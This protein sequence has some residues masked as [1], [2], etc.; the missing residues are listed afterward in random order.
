MADFLGGLM[1]GL[2]GLGLVNQ[3][4]PDVKALNVRNEI[5]ELQKQEKDILASIGEKA[6][7]EGGE[8]RYPDEANQLR[9]IRSNLGLKQQA[10][11]QAEEAVAAKKAEEEAARR[12]AEA[13]ACPN[14]GHENPEGVNFCQECGTKIAREQKLF[15]TACGAENPAGTR[16]CGSCGARLG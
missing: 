15:C 9:L 11:K 16:F 12:A 14:C 10:L 5:A 4:D 1:K 8:G 13:R 7:S 6:L 3:E 2:S